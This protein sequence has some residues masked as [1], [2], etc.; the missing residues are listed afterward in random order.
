MTTK[1]EK[2]KFDGSTV[3]IRFSRS[4]GESTKEAIEVIS[5]EAPLPEFIGALDALAPHVVSLCEFPEEYLKDL[6]VIAI[7]ISDT[8]GLMGAVISAKKKLKSSRSPFII[9]TPHKTDLDPSR[10]LTQK[11]LTIEQ[12]TAIRNLI[13]E[14]ERFLSGKRAQRTMFEDPELEGRRN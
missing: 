6:K 8:E 4:T 12:S 1:I 13:A 14:A 11:T 7:S 2:I 3:T 9:H 10:K 5:E